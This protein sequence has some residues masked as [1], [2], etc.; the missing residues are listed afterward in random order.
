MEL[1]RQVGEAIDKRDRSVNR[2]AIRFYKY[3]GLFRPRTCFH[4]YFCNDIIY[5]LYI[6]KIDEHKFVIILLYEK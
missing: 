1:H 3:K 6:S 2:A 5:F 4:L